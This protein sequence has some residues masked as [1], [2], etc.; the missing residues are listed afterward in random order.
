MWYVT[1]KLYASLVPTNIRIT[2]CR[3]ALSRGGSKKYFLAAGIL[4]ENTGTL[5]AKTQELRGT[6]QQHVMHLFI[7]SHFLN[8]RVFFN[9]FRLKK[10]RRIFVTSGGSAKRIRGCL[11]QIY[12]KLFSCVT[13][14]D[15][16]NW[17]RHWQRRHKTDD[18]LG[19]WTSNINNIEEPFWFQD[20]TATVSMHGVITGLVPSNIETPAT[21]VGL[22][23]NNA[24][25]MLYNHCW[26]QRQDV[27]EYEAV[28]ETTVRLGQSAD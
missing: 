2:L 28:T 14:D 17:W 19:A 13:G 15:T 24:S 20:K 6:N 26:A 27:V 4:R 7:W 22:F 9:T 25:D 16:K 5:F 3:T 12:R 11:V 8:L 1:N 21:M 18:T 10:N 23:G